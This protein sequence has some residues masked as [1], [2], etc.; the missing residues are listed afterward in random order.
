MYRFDFLMHQAIMK[1]FKSRGCNG[2]NIFKNYYI[3]V[4]S[5]YAL[6]SISY[7]IEQQHA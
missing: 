1:I 7:V 5:L 4:A 6:I 2:G 3:K